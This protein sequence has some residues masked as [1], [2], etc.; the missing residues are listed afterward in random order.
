[1]GTVVAHDIAVLDN[2]FIK[3][4]IQSRAFSL[5][6]S[7]PAPE[8]L[9]GMVND[10]VSRCVGST[11]AAKALGGVLCSKTSEEEWKAVLSKTNAYSKDTEIFPI[12]KLTYDDLPPRMKQCFAFCA[13]FP[14]DYTIC[15][16][17][18]IQLWMANGFI[19]EQ[20]E[21]QPEKIGKQ[22]FNELASSNLVQLKHLN[23]CGKLELHQL[24][25]VT[26]ADAK[27]TNLRNKELT[28]LT[29]NWTDDEKEEQHY[30]RVLD[31]LEPNGRLQAL[32]I[33][34]TRCFPAWINMLQ[35]L[36]ELH[37]SGSSFKSWGL[38]E[39]IDGE[40]PTF[41]ALE[42]AYINA[43][44]ELTILPEAP[45]LARQKWDHKSP[46]VELKL[47]GNLFFEPGAQELWTCFV[48]LQRLEIWLC[49]VL[50]HWP[51][52]EFQ[53]LVALKILDIYGCNNLIGY[54][55]GPEPSASRSSQLLP[56]LETLYIRGCAKLVEVF[57][58]PASL[59][60][61]TIGGCPMLESIFRKQQ[62]SRLCE[63][64]RSLPLPDEPGAY[65]SLESLTISHCPGVKTLPKFLLQQLSSIQDKTLDA[66]YQGPM[67][68][69]PK[70]WKYGI[71]RD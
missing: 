36:V 19:P 9:L 32:R 49:D 7:S 69:K 18:L 63:S 21:A 68:L 70:T 61:M 22:I 50:V 5:Q 29:L 40:Q 37:V 52:R 35:N 6:H 20:Q 66:R 27:A 55:R 4:I 3:E 17:M 47:N 2:R 60:V 33:D 30:R 23:L 26:E 44:P 56:F 46:M 1:M 48:Q 38:V 31:G 39:G 71:R 14:K 57:N 51:E 15:A 25:N 67:L 45:K 11:L 12:L 41:P 13:V 34:G 42:T 43:C 8:A 28:S 64:L 58:L 62:D 53:S 59:K 24:E 10:F 16:D 65:S 54:A